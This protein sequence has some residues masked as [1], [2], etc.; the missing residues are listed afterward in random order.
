MPRDALEWFLMGLTLVVIEMNV[1]I[2]AASWALPKSA[3]ET[4]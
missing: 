2:L 1:S 4:D 3:A